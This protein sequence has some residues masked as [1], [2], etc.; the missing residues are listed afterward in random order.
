MGQLDTLETKLDETLRKKAPFQLP[1]DIRNW[2]ATNAWWLSLIG[3]ISIL[4]SVLTLWRA[5][6]YI[7]RVA[8]TLN[9]WAGRPYVHHLGVDYYLSLLLIG[10]AGV[11]MLLAATNLKAMRRTGWQ[12]LFYAALVRVVAALLLIF[13]DYGGFGDFIGA[14]I[15]A[16]VGLYFLFQ[17]RD[18]F[19][20]A[21]VMPAAPHHTL[22][23]PHHD[24]ADAHNHPAPAATDVKD[25]AKAGAD[26]HTEHDARSASSAEHDTSP[27]VPEEKTEK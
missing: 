5:G 3:G 14:L 6:H 26:Q 10:I 11:L 18:R 16:V 17:I 12:Y 23:H 7:D 15:G 8:E 1:A 24:A 19:T 9:Y 21:G 2:I 25:E 4:W 27:E 20:A 13:T 22:A